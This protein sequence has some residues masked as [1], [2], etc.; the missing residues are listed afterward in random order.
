MRNRWPFPLAAFACV[1]GAASAPAAEG[2]PSR[3]IRMI[4]AYAA[5]GG[6]DVTARLLAARLT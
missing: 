5:G 1:L 3:P 4:V 2:Y 6:N